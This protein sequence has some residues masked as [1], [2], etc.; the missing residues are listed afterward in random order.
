[1]NFKRRDFL[2]LAMLVGP[3]IHSFQALASKLNS[4]RSVSSTDTRLP[5]LQGAT[6]A[7][8]TQISILA[9]EAITISVALE[10]GSKSQAK[11]NE[12]V[13]S[14][15]F[16]AWKAHRIHVENLQPKTHY[17]LIITDS[18]GRVIDSRIFSTLD[19]DKKESRLALASCM[20]DNKPGQD[21]MWAAVAESKPD[22]LFLLGDNVYVDDGPSGDEEMSESKIWKRYIET[23]TTLA[24]YRFPV[25]VPTLATWD[26]HD[27]GHN[28]TY[29]YNSWLEYSSKIF[30]TMYPQD[31]IIAEVSQGP[32]ISTSF[33]AFGQQFYFMDNRTFRGTRI[34]G[35]HHWG[36]EQEEWMFKQVGESEEPAWLFSG[37]QFFGGYR[38]G[39][40]FEGTNKRRFKYLM[41]KLQEFKAP[42]LFGSGDVHYTEIMKIEKEK[43]GYETFEVTSSSIHSNAKEPQKGNK[44]RIA[45]IGEYNFVI[46]D[47]KAGK[48]S[49]EMDLTSI[50]SGSKQFF[51]LLG[52]KVTK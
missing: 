38:Y 21:A 17:Q 24:L 39:W 15:T 44:R 41:N 32:G 46:A 23:R 12:E 27:Y 14:R 22:L 33:R 31:G 10:D 43:V 19:P 36:A 45:S 40:S 16:S 30:R 6:N 20:R 51:K 13:A 26:D 28:N 3:V 49:L 4:K 48:Q 35:L 11:I 7:T 8:S 34:I 29:G 52:L 5:I 25:L 42:F 37:S 18:S 47:V 2:K 50:G 1:M 9:N